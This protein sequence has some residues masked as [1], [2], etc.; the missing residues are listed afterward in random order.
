MDSKFGTA[1]PV[2]GLGSEM[3]GRL[4]EDLTVNH[5]GKTHLSNY[6]FTQEYLKR[7][8][9]VYQMQHTTPSTIDNFTPHLI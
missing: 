8:D 3:V 2:S 4:S 1:L 6:T 9:C 5:N 7:D